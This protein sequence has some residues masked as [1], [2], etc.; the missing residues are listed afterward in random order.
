MANSA[1]SSSSK[2]SLVFGIVARVTGVLTGIVAIH[3]RFLAEHPYKTNAATSGLLMGLGDR[4]AQYVEKLRILEEINSY[5]NNDNCNN[6]NP[7]EKNKPTPT[8]PRLRTPYES[9]ARTSILTVWAGCVSSPWWTWWYTWLHQKYPGKIFMW[10]LVTA[11]IPAPFWNCAFFVFSTAAEHAALSSSPW[12][13]R[14]ECLHR[15]QTKLDHQFLPTVVRSAQLWIPVNILNFYFVPLEF[16]MFA[17]SSVAF[18]WNVYLSLAQMKDT[19]TINKTKKLTLS[20]E[21]VDNGN[22]NNSNNTDGNDG[23]IL[24]NFTSIPL[25]THIQYIKT[26][27][28]FEEIEKNDNNSSKRNG[29]P[30][31]GNQLS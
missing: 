20:K 2:A 9:Y 13:Q 26:I 22:N 1:P 25:S 16:R 15:I 27:A 19:T 3:R 12:E 18:A 7:D 10:V 6:N 31:K 11:T 5:N 8:K 28:G 14:F 29:H 17:G 30:P 4:V 23:G 24:K 21:S